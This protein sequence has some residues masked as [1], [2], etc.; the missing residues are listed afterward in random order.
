LRELVAREHDEIRNRFPA[1]R[2]RNAGYALDELLREPGDHRPWSL[3]RLLAGS[4]G[5]L[6]ITASA[7]VGLV[8][9]PPRSAVAMISFAHDLF[10]ALE[11]VPLLLT[12]RPAAIELTDRVL[13]DL[14]RNSPLYRTIAARLLDG[15]TPAAVLAVA[16]HDT[17]QTALEQRIAALTQALAD[18][19]VPCT[20]RPLLDRD[21][22]QAFWTLRRGGLG[23]LMGRT[24]DIKPVPFVEDAAVAPAVLAS[25][26]RELDAYLRSLHV[27]VAY[28][29]HASVGVIHTRPLLDLKQ[30]RDLDLLQRIGEHAAR[31]AVAYGGSISGEHGDGRSRG[32][33][34]PLMYGPRLIKAF[35]SVKD[36]FDPIGVL[37][38]TIKVGCP[39]LTADLRINPS[40][41][42]HAP[43]ASFGWQREGGLARAIEHCNGNAACRQ[44]AGGM[45]CPTFQATRRE[46]DSTRGRA[47]LLREAISGGLPR[48]VDDPA[49]SFALERCLACKGC[50]AE[51]PSQVDL[52]RLK[53]EILADRHRRHGIPLQRQLLALTP[54]LARWGWLA[55]PLWPL[56]QRPA[57]RAA[58]EW[59]LQID[60]RRPL[61]RPV[62]PLSWTWREPLGP[63]DGPVV[64]LWLDTWTDAFAPW[65]AIAARELLIAA[66]CR[67]H[68]FQPG[69][70]GRVALSLGL[71]GAARRALALADRLAPALA[72]GFVVGLEPSCLLACR[73]ELSDW[74]DPSLATRLRERCLLLEEYLVQR[75]GESAAKLSF[76][77]LPARALLQLHCHQQSLGASNATLTAL[78]WIPELEVAALPAGC[79]GMAGLFGYQQ[80]ELSQAIAATRLLPALAAAPTALVL[81]TGFSCRHQLADLAQR[82][83]RHPAELLATQ[84]APSSAS[85]C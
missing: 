44:L 58:L 39:P 52:A 82:N 46:V 8:P 1:L 26:L 11:Q 76:N 69:C 47:N 83:A 78:R 54:T 18:H 77:P 2:R 60:R 48:G 14:A 70:C 53:H 50:R 84:L 38:P 73:D 72:R 25:Y 42:A 33:F 9:R 49:V 62:R 5:T 36:I 71:P 66:G 32:G 30:Q 79:C 45:M 68:P 40:Y 80:L 27:E 24:G 34:L 19:G 51:C 59:L 15:P 74:V 35:A 65:I 41:H 85:S 20:V 81:A 28:Y 57:S 13:L 6:A 7:I 29:A 67:V 64:A 37:H 43:L 17:S 10:N 16:F 23:I 56:V 75:V 63:R 4:E 12:L 31:L 21:E 22:Q 55:G 3:P 61:P